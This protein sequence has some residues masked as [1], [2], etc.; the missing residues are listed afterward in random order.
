MDL[1]EDAVVQGIVSPEGGR[2]WPK[3]CGADKPRQTSGQSIKQHWVDA[4][5]C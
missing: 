4:S 1:L 5:L 3:F 2:A